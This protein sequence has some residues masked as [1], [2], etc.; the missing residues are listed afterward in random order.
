VVEAVDGQLVETAPDGAVKVLKALPKAI[1]VSLGQ[2]V[3]R[4]KK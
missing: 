2:R 1:P 4:L 3:L